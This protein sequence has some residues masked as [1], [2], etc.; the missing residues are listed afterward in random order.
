MIQTDIGA[1]RSGLCRAKW[2]DE[3]NVICKFS[4]RHTIR[5]INGNP[6]GKA[7]CPQNRAYR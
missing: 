1:E 5:L 2:N 4:P 3:T 6:S 7:D